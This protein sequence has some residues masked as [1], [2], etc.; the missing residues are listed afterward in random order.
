M[1][2]Y[3]FAFDLEY[4]P[5]S[6]YMRVCIANSLEGAWDKIFQAESLEHEGD[7]LT[8]EDC[9][10]TMVIEVDP[11]STTKAHAYEMS[12]EGK[13]EEVKMEGLWVE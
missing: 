2:T 10:G 9:R 1:K 6:N 12:E 5:D 11:E 4:A 7:E 13:W 3:L 8:F